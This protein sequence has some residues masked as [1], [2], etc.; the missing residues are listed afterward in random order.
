MKKVTKTC[1]A[2][3]ERPPE[4]GR[5]VAEQSCGRSETFVKWSCIWRPCH[6]SYV[7][8]RV[9]S[10]PA[11]QVVPFRFSH[12]LSV[13]HKNE[14]ENTCVRIVT[15]IVCNVGKVSVS[16]LPL[17]TANSFDWQGSQIFI[18]NPSILKLVWTYF[19]K[20]PIHHCSVTLP[21]ILNRFW[22]CFQ[23]IGEG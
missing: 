23:N 22:R 19:C 20:I 17:S 6:R 14:R 12:F 9:R 16:N 10:T 18:G 2:L 5:S 13:K 3:K 4:L 7:R 8:V 21:S 15:S 11:S 1:V